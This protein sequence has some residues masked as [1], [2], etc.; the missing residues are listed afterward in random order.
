MLMK[1]KICCT[2]FLF[3]ASVDVC[4]PKGQ[5]LIFDEFKQTCVDINSVPDCQIG[6]IFCVFR[7]Y[8]HLF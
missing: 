1:V 5:S 3:S 7:R 4:W 8:K 2:L 6:T